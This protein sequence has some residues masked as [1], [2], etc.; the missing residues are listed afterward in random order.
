MLVSGTSDEYFVSCGNLTK[1]KIVCQE[2]VDSLH[3]VA[4][5]KVLS[6]VAQTKKKLTDQ[7]SSV[8]NLSG[9]VLR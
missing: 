7:Q 6:G 4:F 8:L 5:A 2:L 3:D 9:M 1:L